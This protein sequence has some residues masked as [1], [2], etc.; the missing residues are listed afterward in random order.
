MSLIQ[1]ALKRQMDEKAG[2]PYTP[3]PTVAAPRAGGI[4]GKIVGMVV[5]LV[6]LV[7]V[8]GALF[9]LATKKWSWKDA[10]QA[11]SADLSKAEQK[12][13]RMASSVSDE[14][15]AQ[16]PVPA[17]PVASAVSPAALPHASVQARVEKMKTAVA[18][19]TKETSGSF[20]SAPA[21]APAA[22]PAPSPTPARV[23]EAPPPVAAPAAQKP[24][25]AREPAPERAVSA[26][27]WPRIT[28]N[29]IMSAGRANGAAL[30]NN[31][32]VGVGESVE[33]VRVVEVQVKGAVMEYKGETRLLLIGQSTD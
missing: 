24:A 4:V 30:V 2:K 15:P 27:P 21:P 26:G 7:S 20:E 9:Y 28:L 22:V 19:Y 3:P 5:A 18:D 17:A 31:R 8:A 13:T 25:V 23:V 6:L 10:M 14:K 16:A 29:G 33:G 32:M 11:A 1:E 12:I